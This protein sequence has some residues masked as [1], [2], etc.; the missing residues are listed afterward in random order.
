PRTAR[1]RTTPAAAVPD[2]QPASGPAAAAGPADSGLPPLPGEDDGPTD[3]ADAGATASTAAPAPS[4][5]APPD[6]TTYDTPG[7]ATTPQI[8]A[9]WT[10]LSNVYKFTKDEKDQ[11]RAVCAQ[12]CG[13]PLDS[14]K[15]MSKN[16][17]KA[18]LDTLGNWREIADRNDTAP[19]EF[20]VGIMAEHA[21]A[22]PQDGDAGA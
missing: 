22:A 20:L 4:Q 16:E 12:V 1:R 6:E 7:T 3:A 2:E 13:H 19:R 14:T 10:V 21:A 15:D 17:A 5:T 8:T 18:V 9:I 11:A